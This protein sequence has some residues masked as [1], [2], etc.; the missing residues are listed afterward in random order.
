MIRALVKP[1]QAVEASGIEVQLSI[2]EEH[3]IFLGEV[4][5]RPRSLTRMC[6][7]LFYF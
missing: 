6:F 7:V 3:S 5:P 4:V 2:E 1:S